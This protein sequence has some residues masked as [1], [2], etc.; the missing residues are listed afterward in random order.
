MF[1]IGK[2]LLLG[3]KFCI[4]NSIVRNINGKL[5]INENIYLVILLLA[6]KLGY[7]L[8]SN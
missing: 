3:P 7:K 8:I 1:I 4:L 2:I 5:T 6:S